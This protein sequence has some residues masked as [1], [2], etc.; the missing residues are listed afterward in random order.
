M[1]ISKPLLILGAAATL[2]VL[3]GCGSPGPAGSA[4]AS[5]AVTRETASP[6]ASPGAAS[7]PSAAVA[8]AEITIKGF[9]YQGPES[10]APGAVITVTNEDVEAHT[11]TAD[12]G[13]AF[14]AAAKVGTQTFMAPTEPGSYPFHCL[15]HGNMHGTLV[16]K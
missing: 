11:V 2:A 8:P 12:Q 15:F 14:D 10:V 3:T 16:V 5:S 4:P 6:S 7:T 9:K 1:N 13:G